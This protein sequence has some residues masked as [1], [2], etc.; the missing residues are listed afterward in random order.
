MVTVWCIVFMI[1]LGVKMCD[2]QWIQLFSVKKRWHVS[3]FEW[4]QYQ[5]RCVMTQLYPVQEVLVV[6]MELQEG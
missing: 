1:S 3:K 5:C 2:L 6:A 4:L